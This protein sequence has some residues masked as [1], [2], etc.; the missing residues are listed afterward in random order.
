LPILRTVSAAAPQ[1]MAGDAAGLVALATV[2]G[3]A[4]QRPVFYSATFADDP[5]GLDALLAQPD[6]ALVVTDTNRKQG[7][8]WGSVRDN[9][10]Y[11]ERA[12]EQPLETD[13]ADNRLDV[14]PDAG[15]DQRTVVEQRG[16]A[17]VAAS[18]YGNNVTY[19][20]GDRAVKALDGDESTGWK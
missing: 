5:A 1:V 4:P 18:A 10:G 7:T 11:T 19:T 9:D 2:G 8:R 12:G 6:A 14:F 3:L 16:G 13:L 15:D 17:T 20:P